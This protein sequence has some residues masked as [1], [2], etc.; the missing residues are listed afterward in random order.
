MP[1]RERDETMT[2]SNWQFFAPTKIVFGPG[3][4]GT[5]ADEIKTLGVSKVLIATDKGVAKAGV[6]QKVVDLIRAAGLEVT[7]FDEVEPNPSVATVEK[8]YRLYKENGCQ[9]AIGVGGGSSMDTAK[10][11]CILATNEGPITRFEGANKVPNTPAPSIAVPTTA[12]TGAEVT[13]TC[14]ITDT[15]RNYKVS[16]R[17]TLNVCKVAILDPQLLTSLP[18]AVVASTGMD[19]LAH[20]VESYLSTAASPL[21]EALSLEATRVIANRLRAFVANP[22]DEQ[23]AADMLYASM[24]AGLAFANGRLT[25]VHAIAHAVGGHFHVAHG[26]G[27]ALMLAPVMEFC[28][29]AAAA[30][31]AKVAEVMGE[32]I[33]GLSQEQAAR[34]AVDAVV[35]LAKDIGVPTRLAEVGVTADKIDVLAADSEASGIQN[36]TPRKPT[37]EEIKNLIKNAM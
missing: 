25:A 1:Q 7:I 20:A 29:P 19:A 30:K 13:Q 21:T 31:M 37:L 33:S 6:L 24:T 4:I 32:D 11:T 27:C 10:A 23:A 15:S 17:S 28:I 35:K 34:K 14:V 36:T 2:L 18:P 9:M 16:I 3:S 5:I 12:G 22:A 8:C 26:V